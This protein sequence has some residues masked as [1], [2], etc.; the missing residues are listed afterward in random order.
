MAPQKLPRSK[1]S[2]SAKYY[3]DNP[4][5]RAKK[6]ATDTKVNQRPVQRKKRSEL[7]TARARMVK[8][9]I[10]VKWK[11]LSHTKNWIRLKKS[12]ANRG[13]KSD[14]AWDRKARGGWKK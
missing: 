4:K 1:L 3:R 2:K 8:K 12:S 13:N 7:K 5:A 9:W 14:T 11:D 6:K 10:N